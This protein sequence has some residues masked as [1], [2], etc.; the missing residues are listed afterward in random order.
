MNYL[1]FK[2]A[3]GPG[4]GW[5]PAIVYDPRLTDSSARSLAKK[6]LGKMH[7][8]YFFDCNEAPFT[9]LP[10]EKLVDWEVGLVWGYDQGVAAR[11]S[12]SAKRIT[13]F[14]G[15]LQQ[16]HVEY[17]KPVEFRCDWN[18][19]EVILRRNSSKTI[20]KPRQSS[21]V[22]NETVSTSLQSKSDQKPWTRI[23]KYQLRR[24]LNF[25]NEAKRSAKVFRCGIPEA[26]KRLKDQTHARN[27]IGITRTNRRNFDFLSSNDSKESDL[28]HCKFILRQQNANAFCICHIAIPRGRESCFSEGR[29][30]VERLS[31]SNLPKK[32]KFYVPKLGPISKK[33]ESTLQIWSFLNEVNARF[34]EGS[35]RN[36]I[37][38]I[39]QNAA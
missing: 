25:L 11:A 36:P 13:S 29:K 1:M 20:A 28:L 39:L 3:G 27:V 38:I 32:W 19:D 18:H 35:Q 6:N 10:P 23:S 26:I 30:L 22:E 21:P 2:A 7:L 33:Q 16:A 8:V 9:V 4:F 14:E 34:G 17:N 5:W 31:P 24:E 37:R 12:G 15:A